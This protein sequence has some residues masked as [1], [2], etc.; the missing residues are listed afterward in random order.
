MYALNIVGFHLPYL[1]GFGYDQMDIQVGLGTGEVG[2]VF[3]GK[4]PLL[5]ARIQVIDPG[6]KGPLVCFFVC[7]FSFVINVFTECR[8]NLHRDPLG[9][10]TS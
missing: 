6:L 2:F 4:H 8:T 9:P 1:I 7:S 3:F 5:V 10:I